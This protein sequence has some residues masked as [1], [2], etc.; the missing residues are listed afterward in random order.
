M[1]MKQ[2]SET[3]VHKIQTPGFHS[4]KRLQRNN[5]AYSVTDFHFSWY[6][7]RKRAPI[8]DAAKPASISDI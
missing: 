8:F 5:L 7:F 1:K 3:S 2:C 4:K 6:G